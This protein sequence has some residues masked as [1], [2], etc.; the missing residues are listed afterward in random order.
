RDLPVGRGLYNFERIR[1]DYYRDSGVELQA[2]GG[3]QFGQ[4]CVTHGRAPG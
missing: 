2:H 3:G 1:F 4:A